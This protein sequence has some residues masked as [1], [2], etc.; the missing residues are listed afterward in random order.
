MNALLHRSALALLGVGGAATGVWAYVAPCHWYHNFPGLGM[1]WLPQLG[2]Y[3]EHLAKDVGAMFLAMA[4]LTAVTFIL[5]ANQ[6]LVRVTALMWLVFNTLHCIYHLSMLQMYNTRDA[7][8]NAILLPMLVLAAAALLSP[9]RINQ[10]RLHASGSQ[11]D[12]GQ[13]S[14]VAR[15]AD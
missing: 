15:E 8:L 2:P 7:T 4:A 5:V 14:P 3:N 6:T 9:V 10:Q 11:I 13:R 1:S 12:D